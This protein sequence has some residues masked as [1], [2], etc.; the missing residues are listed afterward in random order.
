MVVGDNALK[1]IVQHTPYDRRW[2][3][4]CTANPMSLEIKTTEKLSQNSKTIKKTPD[5]RSQDVEFVTKVVYTMRHVTPTQSLS[6]GSNRRP[7][8]SDQTILAQT[9]LDWPAT[10]Q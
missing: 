9:G 3:G 7:M 1:D 8:E 5:F 6:I 2:K 10:R 4:R